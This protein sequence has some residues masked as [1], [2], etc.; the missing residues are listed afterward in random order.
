MRRLL[1]YLV[2]STLSLW[3]CAPGTAT[4]SMVHPDLGVISIRVAKATNSGRELEYEY[5]Y[6]R[7]KMD[8]AD[9]APEPGRRVRHGYYRK[10]YGNGEHREE[11]QYTDGRMTGRWVTYS[12]DGSLQAEGDFSD[13]R[14][15]VTGYHP[16]GNVRFAGAFIQSHSGR[17][18]ET[19]LPSDELRSHAMWDGISPSGRQLDYWE[20]GTQKREVVPLPGEGERKRITEYDENGVKVCQGVE[21]NGDKVGR[22]KWYDE[23]GRIMMEG[24]FAPGGL[25]ARR[26]NMRLTYTAAYARDGKWTY[27]DKK[28]ALVRVETYDRGRIVGVVDC[29][30]DP[31]GCAR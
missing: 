17:P 22:W 19:S 3:K 11:G 27:Y 21:Q 23:D 18:E 20:S 4:R 30:E 1:L 14:G 24:G 12:E 13:G 29:L 15:K 16:N 10:H 8:M 5:Y 9:T 28:A 26:M 2:L 25:S 6:V 31:V 7:G